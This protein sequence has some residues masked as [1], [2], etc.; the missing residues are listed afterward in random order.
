MQPY[1]VRGLFFEQLIRKLLTSSGYERVSDGKVLGRGEEHQIDAFG[2]FAFTVPFTYPIRLICEAK[3]LKIGVHLRHVR[4]FE[5][6][7]KDISE[8]YFTGRNVRAKDFAWKLLNRYLDCGAFFS[9]NYFTDN[10]QHY[11]YAQ[12]MY[13]VPYQGNRVLK[14]VLTEIESL[15]NQNIDQFE[16][17]PL[18]LEED[19]KKKTYSR[20]AGKIMNNSTLL[21]NLLS[22]IGTYLGILD[23]VY[24]V[25]ILTREQVPFDRYE[26]D[27]HRIS[28]EKQRLDITRNSLHFVFRDTK[29]NIFEFTL[30]A[31][32]GRGLIDVVRRF[33]KGAAFSYIDIP[34][35]IETEEGSF[36]RIFRA[37]IDSESRRI[38]HRRLAEA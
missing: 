12:G 25:H 17:G 14:S 31:Q 3:W 18:D 20:M 38:I 2:R 36:R 30:P 23:G 33:Y 16:K 7:I 15:A 11:A 24:P 19:K 10:A 35:V 6:V 32:V 26:K 29:R 34:T 8:N 27:E 21:N 13:L 22:R 9:A 4:D 1:Q 5:G 37:T 28:V